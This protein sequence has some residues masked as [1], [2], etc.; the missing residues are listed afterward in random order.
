M[1]HT[2]ATQDAAIALFD[3]LALQDNYLAIGAFD[4]KK[5]IFCRFDNLN[6]IFEVPYVAPLNPVN[7]QHF[8]IVVTLIHA[9]GQYLLQYHN[10]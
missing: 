10:L 3:L 5:F 4:S 8:N 9:I 1:R 7:H 2:I 6:Q